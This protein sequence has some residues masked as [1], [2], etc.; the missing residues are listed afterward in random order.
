MP[1]LSDRQ[2][3]GYAALAFV[4]TLLANFY[5][6]GYSITLSGLL[7]VIFLSV[8]V[9][10]RSST[11]IAGVVSF[12]VVCGFLVRDIVEEHGLGWSQY[13]FMALLV[14]FTTLIVLY[15]KSLIQRMQFDE[16]HMTSLFE[17]ATEG[18]ILTNNRAEIVLVNPA[19]CR[20]FGYEEEELRGQLIESLIPKKYRTGHVQLR[21][22][23]YEGPSN[24][25]MGH[26]R[27]LNG[28]RKDGSTFPVEVS[29]S[30]YRQHDVHYA[31][32]FIVDITQR[33]EAERSMLEQQQQ[34]EKV[35]NDVR[36]LNAELEVKVEERTLILKEALQRLEQSQAELSEAL[37]KERQLNE[38]KSRFVSM[39]SHEFRTP[40]S[41]V[42][43]SASL[44]AKYTT[45]EQ[46]ANRDRHI[47]RIRESVKHLNDLLED[48]LSLGKLD[49]G[50]IGA[51]MDDFDL[52]E[53]ITDC[54]DEVRGLVKEGQEIHYEHKGGTTVY[55]DKRLL[56]N[57]LINLVS[58]ALKFSD[59][60]STVEVRSIVA[61]D[62]VLLTVRD[63][64]IGISEEDQE[65][66]FSTFFRGR[67]ALN[68]QGTGLG[69]HIVK[70]YTDLMG[71]TINLNSKLG[72]GTTVTLRLPKHA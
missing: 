2:A 32:A 51:Q 35:T 8:F 72:E 49:E 48:F 54:L 41:A 27:D 30:S 66:L 17:N 18:I 44:L 59:T 42:L 1:Q 64:G 25:K 26:G 36:K 40:L 62:E 60:G 50:K 37:D 58:N 9:S 47:N 33:K 13:G 65:H 61:D 15:I 16:S 55:N 56:R 46:Q 7:V 24:R 38:I 11:I 3:S 22:E 70:R 20:M 63:R 67:N 57:I 6:P 53:N 23:F 5:L 4:L 52:P 68:I 28:Q 10:T 71:G 34:L 43:S 19:A 14:L 31:I 39:A 21:N 69:L 29:L 12:L 45:T